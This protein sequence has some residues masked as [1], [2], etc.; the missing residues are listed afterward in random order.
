MSVSR[1]FRIVVTVGTLWITP[2]ASAASI[3]EHATLVAVN[4]SGQFE[5]GPIFK[6]S[7]SAFDNTPDFGRGMVPS[8]LATSVPAIQPD[9]DA[10]LNP[11][12]ASLFLLGTGLLLA[13]KLQTSRRRRRAPRPPHHRP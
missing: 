6:K 11:E 10:L 5:N 1:A 12:P 13:V 7:A 9:S 4:P 8:R 3:A 2:S